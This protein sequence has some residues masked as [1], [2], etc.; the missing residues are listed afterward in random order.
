MNRLLVTLALI[1]APVVASA[2]PQTITI[3]Y[4]GDV[5]TPGFFLIASTPPVMDLNSPPNVVSGAILEAMSKKVAD[6]LAS[7][8]RVNGKQ[9]SCKAVAFFNRND[10]N[11]GWIVGLS[12][13]KS[14]EALN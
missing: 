12:S 11:A 8:E 13:L 5:G 4:D 6:A 1:L 3:E 14:C 9:Y 2:T 7:L 10:S